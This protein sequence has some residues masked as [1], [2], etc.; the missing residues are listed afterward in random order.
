MAARR[1]PGAMVIIAALVLATAAA[2]APPPAR[3]VVAE[4][5]ALA[6]VRILPGAALNFSQIEQSAPERFSDAQ[7]RGADG[8]SQPAR[9]IEFH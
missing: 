7:I 5:Q 9:L 8:S 2:E 3:H 1:V 4:R 6:M